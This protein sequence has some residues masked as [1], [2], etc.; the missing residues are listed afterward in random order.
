MKHLGSVSVG[1]L[2]GHDM[3]LHVGPFLGGQFEVVR[4]GGSFD[5]DL[6]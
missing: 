6:R 3:P 1:L 2:L 5:D 4:G